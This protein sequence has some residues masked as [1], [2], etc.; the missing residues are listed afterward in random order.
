MGR[1]T[2]EELDGE[3]ACCSYDHAG[4]R[5]TRTGAGRT[6]HYRYNSRNQLTELDSTAGTVRYE[7]DPAGSLTAEVHTAQG[8]SAA[9]RTGYTYDAYNRNTSVCGA[10]YV[11]Q[12]HYDAEGL[13]YAVTENGK[14]T[15][16][17][18]RNGMP[19]SELDADKNP[20][21]G[22]ILGN[23]YISH[24]DGTSFGYYL[25]D[26]QGSVR[27]LTGSD[28]SIRNHYR[29]SAFGET[30]TAEETVPNRLRYNGQ[31][32][33]GLT[34]LYY[35]RA[36]YY[37]A[38]LGR[39]TQEDVIYN[40]GL[41]LYAYCNSNPVM[42]SDPSGFAKQ[43]DPK[44]GGEKDSKSDS[45]SLQDTANKAAQEYNAKYNPYERAISK[46]YTDVKKT[47][48]GGVSFQG[49]EYMYYHNGQ[50][51]RR[52]I[53]AT[54][55]RNNDFKMANQAMGLSETPD[56]Y[57]WHHLD[58]YN[59]EKNTITMELVMDEAHN[60]SKPHSGGC[61]QY[62]SVNGPTYNKKRR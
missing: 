22:Y 62:D 21:R 55:N 50:E 5:L 48:N 13:R 19:V 49:S 53:Q 33:D 1:L 35:L 9:E 42:Y 51:A 28:G 61:A 11:Q 56:D 8:G 58:D 54:G 37:N 41:N 43:C 10:G 4:N 57:V 16:F 39:F 25:N 34:G 44:V 45:S 29:Y 23:E 24:V 30:I 12:N 15:N 32:A 52:V 20:V 36:R 14:T 46:G 59:V 31:M 3:T 6:E 18:Y 27:Y 47:A 26:E 2:G 17:V 40:D 60:A 7:Y 38:S